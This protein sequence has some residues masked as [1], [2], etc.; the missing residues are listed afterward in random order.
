MTNEPY[1][2]WLTEDGILH[3]QLWNTVNEDP[4]SA[5]E[6]ATL[7]VSNVELIDWTIVELK[8]FMDVWEFLPDETDQAAYAAYCDDNSS[9]ASLQDFESEYLCT[10]TSFVD[11]VQELADDVYDIPVWLEGHIDW[12]SVADEWSLDY[13]ILSVPQGVAIFLL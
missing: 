11:Y 4:D 2:A 6:F 8:E 5:P 7:T 10:M 9:P 3:E 13:C 12:E 1:I